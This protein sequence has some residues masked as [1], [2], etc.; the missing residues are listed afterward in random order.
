V[1]EIAVVL[2]LVALNGL[3]ALSELA[4]VSSRRSRLRALAEQGRRGARRALE[5]ASDPGRFLSTVQI[6]IT[7]V[8]LIAGA[9]S[10]ATLTKDLERIL[11]ARGVPDTM[12]G[13]ASYITVFAAITY[14]SLIIGELVPKNLALRHAERI[15]C[16]VAPLMSFLSRAAAPAVWLL[17]ASTRVVFFILRQRQPTKSTVTEEE[18]KSLIAEAESAGVLESGEHRLISGVLRLGDR[19]VRGLMTPRSDVDWVDLT[20]SKEQQIA[21]I[22]ATSHTRV[23]VGT[24]S[25]D[26]LVGVLR[27]REPLAALATGQEFDIQ[28]YV[29]KAPIVPETMDAL[30]ALEMLQQAEVPMALIHDEY[31]HFEGIVT[32]AD[33]LEAIAGMFRSDAEGEEPSAIPRDDGSWLLA[34]WMPADEMAD[35][36]GITL[37]ARRDYQTVAGFVLA[38]LMHL[39][40]TGE[41]VEASGWRFEVVDLDGRRVDK[42]LATRALPTRRRIGS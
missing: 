6:G 35:Q 7:A 31:G 40:A 5:L 29:R 20:A 3:F 27:T 21:A 23:P 28:A 16:A 10:G 36:L 41:A 4:L 38:H 25:A 1:F 37:P 32:P 18:I 33:V 11:V 12:A 30:E 19:P 15:A 39:P 34:G 26:M 42:V 17:D 24:G 9:Y 14:V 22:I 2:I 8:G 13:W